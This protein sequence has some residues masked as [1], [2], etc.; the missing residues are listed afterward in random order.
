MAETVHEAIYKKVKLDATAE[1][2]YGNDFAFVEVP[3][4]IKPP[5]TVAYQVSDTNVNAFLC[6]DYQGQASY[7][8]DLFIENAARDMNQTIDGINR[9]ENLKRW[10]QDNFQ[11]LVDGDIT[12]DNAVITDVPDRDSE[13]SDIMLFGFEALFN[14]R[15][16]G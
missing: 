7:Q 13:E 12:I 3:G 5:Y 6:Y 10:V 16:T 1:S 14:W 11:G 4:N 15:Y 9:R 8:F 2:Y